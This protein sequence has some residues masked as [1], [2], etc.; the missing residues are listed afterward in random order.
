VYGLT[1]V[2]EPTAEP[3]TL[4]EAKAHLRVEH[5]YD[6]LTIAALITAARKYC[7]T[8]AKRALVTQT[9]RLTRDTFPGACDGWILRLPRPPLQSVTSIKYATDAGRVRT[10]IVSSSHTW[11]ASGSGT[12]EYYL[13][14]EIDVQPSEL[15]IN[16]S[17][18]ASGTLGSLTAGQWGYGDNDAL[19]F[20]TVYVRLSGGGD[21]DSQAS[22]Y[23]AYVAG[24]E[25]VDTDVYFVDTTSL[26]GRVG[27]A[28]EQE[29]PTDV[30]AGIGAVQV[31]YV[32]GYG[33]ASA[34]PQT[35]KHA[36]LLLI[37]HWYVNREAVGPSMSDVPMA[38]SSLLGSEWAGELV[39]DF[40]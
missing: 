13:T 36:I 29:W 32:A 31:N 5:E 6:D 35:I 4:D 39:G 1:V 8:V 20:D 14:T 19:G 26:P 24:L 22:G 2:T 27:L 12:N 40:G 28:Y 18:A 3:V 17:S 38:V 9:L 21:P 34:V 11:T 33:A 23:I 25:T 7:E 10:S 16:G 15:Y 37:G 30:T